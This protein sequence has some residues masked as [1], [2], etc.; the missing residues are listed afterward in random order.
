MG[1]TSK[2]YLVPTR[3]T[4]GSF[5]LFVTPNASYNQCSAWYN[6]SL[7]VISNVTTMAFEPKY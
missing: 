5:L 7:S 2:S 4:K 6:V 3:N 1:Y